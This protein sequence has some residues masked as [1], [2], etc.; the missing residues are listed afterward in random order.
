MGPENVSQYMTKDCVINVLLG[1]G[2]KSLIPF[3]EGQYH[4]NSKNTFYYSK[5][6]QRWLVLTKIPVGPYGPWGPRGP[7]L[8]LG[9]G[10]PIV[11]SAPERPGE[12]LKS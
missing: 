9:P 5:T 7:W 10:F 6:T 2:M 12:P 3:D 8:P 4:Q 1:F 11:P